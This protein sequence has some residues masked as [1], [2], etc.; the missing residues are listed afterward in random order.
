MTDHGHDGSPNLL[1]LNQLVK[2]TAVLPGSGVPVHREERRGRGDDAPRRGRPGYIG[3][4]ADCANV[5]NQPCISR[6]AG[7]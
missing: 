1:A 6:A 3:L 4:L 5:T 7:S 2:R